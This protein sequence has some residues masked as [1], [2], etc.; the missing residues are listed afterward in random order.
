MPEDSPD[1][2]SQADKPAEKG[3]LADQ[4]ADFILKLLKPGGLAGAGIGAYW[5]AFVENNLAKAVL[6]AGIGVGV[7]W[8]AAMLKPLDDGTK[9]RLGKMGEAADRQIDATAKKALVDRPFEERYFECQTLECLEAK[10]IGIPQYHGVFV[11]LL[12]QIFVDLA[13][14]SRVQMAG[15]QRGE[16]LA[17]DAIARR[18]RIQIWNSLQQ[19]ERSPTYRR[20]AL[21]AWGGY[22]KTTLL[23]QIAYV[24]SKNKQ[25]RGLKRKVPVLIVLS[26]YRTVLATEQ[27]PSL[28]EFIEKRYVPDLP[29]GADLTVPAEWGQG[30]LQDGRAVVLLDG[31]DEVPPVLRPKLIDWIN[32]QTRRYP[33]VVFILTSRPRAYQEAETSAQPLESLTSF[34]VKEFNPQQRQDFIYRWYRCQE[35]LA[36][37]GRDDAIV[38]QTAQQAAADL[39]AQI[40]HRSELQDMARN[41]LL[42][43]M[44]TTFH[45]RN[46]GANL[47]KRRVEL[48]QE[49]CRLQLKE[50]PGA[51]KLETS[52]LN[53]DA[54]AI[55]QPLALEMMMQQTRRLPRAAV[56]SQLQ[57]TLAASSEPIDAIEFL[58]QVV[59]VSELLI[60]QEDEYE[61]AHL[62]FQEYLAAAQI[63]QTQQEPL[64]Y[65]HLGKTG[66]FADSWLRLLELY[67]T[68]V[69][70]TALI[71]EALRQNQPT[72]AD[73][74]YRETTKQIDDPTLAAALDSAL[75]PALNAAKY[76]RLEAL[77]RAGEW[78]EADQETY[79]LMI[80]TVG[81]EKGEYFDPEDLETFPC[82]DLRALDHLWV[83]YSSGKFGFSVQKKIWQECGSPT[84]AG[85][86]W[87]AFCVKVDWKDQNAAW[88]SYS[89][90]KFNPSISPAGELPLFVCFSCLFGGGFSG[91]SLL[92]RRDL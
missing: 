87:D 18:D 78:R 16:F 39:E 70:P 50:R 77:M 71:R 62:S 48:Y 9:R 64:L 28:V 23:R 40:Q 53:C 32:A 10:S 75:Q 59:E 85:K 6:A 29:S 91:V 72:L 31:L 69:N 24:Y 46:H 80:T 89:D 5:A 8:A 44:M 17:P 38:Q 22:G 73:K 92:S 36:R 13:L 11:P 1:P 52:L 21:L 84:Q 82:E 57:Q 26:K 37:G 3:P 7:S 49:I 61:F 4:V 54:Q 19:A 27:P 25:P 20:L 65:A 47:P 76:Q 83:K 42:L 35:V 15:W 90:S 55:L 33:K 67:V 14:D 41:P 60:P 66:G 45:R 56:L 74:L 12:E 81:K 34:W 86:Q 51:R 30:I 63:V 58:Q 79:R 2:N 43:T 68:L 88:M